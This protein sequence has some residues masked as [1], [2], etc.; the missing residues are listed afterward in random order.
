MKE[1]L[2][3]QLTETNEKLFGDAIKHSDAIASNNTP[4]STSHKK[5]QWHFLVGQTQ[6]KKAHF[7]KTKISEVRPNIL[8]AL[9][10]YV[11]EYAMTRNI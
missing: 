8:T 1:F 9:R 2:T 11:S 5:E 3:I 7:G 4:W 10:R 6:Q